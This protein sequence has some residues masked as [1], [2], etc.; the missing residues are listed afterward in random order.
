MRYNSSNQELSKER[1]YKFYIQN[2]ALG[3]KSTLDHFKAE[4]IPKSTIYS[5]IERTEK[6]IQAKR[7]VGSGRVA[8]K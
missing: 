7:V 3:K 4:N 2:K 1:V 6:G 8:Q 5:I